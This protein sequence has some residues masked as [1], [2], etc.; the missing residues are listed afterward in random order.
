MIPGVEAFLEQYHMIEQSDVVVAGVSGGADSVCL[1]LHLLELKEKL[2]FTLAAVHVQH[3]IRGEESLQ[4]AAFVE[5]LCRRYQV[6]LFRY[7]YDVPEYAKQH[8]YSEEEAGRNL[9]YKSFHKALEE[10]G[11][12]EGKIAVAH[13]RNDLAETMLWNMI[14]GSGMRGMAG[15]P[16]VRDGVIRPLLHTA[17]V[18]IENYLKEK[19]E[20][21]CTDATNA[22]LDYTRNRIR[23]Q[24]LP[25]LEELNAG[26]YA[27]MEQLGDDIRKTQEYLSAVIEEKRAQYVERDFR[28]TQAFLISEELLKE[29]EILYTS[30][31]KECICETAASSKD[32]TRTHVELVQKLFSM[33]TGRSVNL[34]YQ[35]VAERTYGGVRLQKCE[36][37]PEHKI[38]EPVGMLSSQ[39]SSQP[40]GR[41]SGQPAGCC[42]ISIEEHPDFACRIYKREEL[43]EGISKKKYTKWLDYD[44]IKNSLLI[45]N[46]Q[47]GDYFV[48][49]ETGR[50][51]KLKQY[52]VNEKILKEQ[53]DTIPLVAD[54]AHILWI[55]GYRISAYYKVSSTTKTILEI[56]YYGGREDNE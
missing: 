4:D 46:R 17:R 6:Q 24:V 12:P 39:S 56:Q 27:H 9:R 40:V 8:G 16:P 14:R 15:I 3:G 23:N 13:N 43:P 7:D 36:K 18:E 19:G 38:T 35:V 42:G 21:Y 32:I 28:K 20:S 45:R 47:P 54:G 48:L 2:S 50:T 11:A 22:S 26:V 10:L 44:K 1:L 33:Q 5:E 31:I 41:Q 49:D 30:I 55:V 52:F 25:V 29:P 37:Q 34:P 51:Q 53:R